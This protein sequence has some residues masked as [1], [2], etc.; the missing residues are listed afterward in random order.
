MFREYDVEVSM[1]LD[2]FEAKHAAQKTIEQSEKV[3]S[4]EEQR[5]VSKMVRDGVRAGLAL[6]EEK[7]EE[8]SKLKKELSAT[9]LQFIVRSELSPTYAL[10]DAYF[11]RETI[12]G[13]RS[14]EYSS[15]WVLIHSEN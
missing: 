4:A 2:L 5:L 14:V 6:S 3:L 11:A 9:C 7:R 1:R 10:T 8:L 13:R 12:A 15:T